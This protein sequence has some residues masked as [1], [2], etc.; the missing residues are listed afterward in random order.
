M[1]RENISSS[2]S[3][4]TSVTTQ[5]TSW[6][7]DGCRMRRNCPTKTLPGLV[8]SKSGW[9]ETVCRNRHPN[10]KALQTRMKMLGGIHLWRG[11]ADA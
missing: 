6:Q 7:E 4:N 1:E 8:L 11:A 10:L 5:R 2:S 9:A 3:H